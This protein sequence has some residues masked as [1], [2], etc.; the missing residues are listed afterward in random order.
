MAQQTGILPIKGSIGGMSF[1]LLNGKQVLRR[2]AGSTA[3]K[4]RD[5]PSFQRTRENVAEFGGASSAGKGLR[6]AVINPFK[7]MADAFVTARATKLCRMVMDLATTG[8]RGQRPFLPAAHKELFLNFSYSSHHSFY[9]ILQAPY[10]IALTP[11]RNSVTVTLP[12]F[13]AANLLNAPP[14][15][16]HFQLQLVL[17]LLSS[18]AYDPLTKR[19]VALSPE[20][21]T[22]HATTASAQIAVGGAMGAELVMTASLPAAVIVP[23]NCV[24]LA[25]LGIEFYQFV[26]GR[27]YRMAM[28]HAMKIAAVG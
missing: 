11:E 23:T 22:V 18:Y 12:D 2:N 7:Q 16:T 25:G 6:M 14:G 13:D 10:S 17:G 4:L 3:E 9:S 24:A 8:I 27:Y 1:Y 20:E 5:S 15:A 26:A 21:N 19:Y 28:G